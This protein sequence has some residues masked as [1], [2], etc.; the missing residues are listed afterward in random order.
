MIV[1]AS[2]SP[3]RGEILTNAGIAF[4]REIPSQI[5]ETPLP[6]EPPRQYVERLAREKAE[7]IPSQ[8]GRIVLGAD[9]TVVIED[10]ILGKPAGEADA[11]RM[12]GLLS[13][14]E[15]QVITGLCLRSERGQVVEA[16]TTR[17]WFATLSRPE[18]DAYVA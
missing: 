15:H 1:L 5:D 2:G 13:G 8:A 6:G 14:R 12:L 3:R 16:A 18:I 4:V 7:A 10:E 17:V 11:A 9:T